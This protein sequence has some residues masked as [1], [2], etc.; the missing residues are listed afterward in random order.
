MTIHHHLTPY[1][2]SQTGPSPVTRFLLSFDEPATP[3]AEPAPD[4][5]EEAF[6]AHV[7]RALEEA[8]DTGRRAAAWM[9]ALPLPAGSWIAGPL[10]DAVEEA[11]TG[12]NPE[13]HDDL[14][15][16]GHAGVSES[17]RTRLDGLP[18]AVTETTPLT[19]QQTSA[20]FAL[21]H[22]VQGIPKTLANDPRGVIRNGDLA[23]LCAIINDAA[24]PPDSRP[25]P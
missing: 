10:A 15:R 11:M 18:Y 4:L 24:P 16:Y 22:C 5:E 13:D 21:V 8:A 1:P 17:A 7:A 9:R 12:L 19:P 20:L 6:Q 2:G 3:E 23:A 25:G 14:D